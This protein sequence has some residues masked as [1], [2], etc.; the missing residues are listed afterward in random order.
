MLGWL[1]LKNPNSRWEDDSRSTWN[2]CGR[3]LKI[4]ATYLPGIH[5][6]SAGFELLPKKRTYV[7]SKRIGYSTHTQDM[8]HLDDS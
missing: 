2:R 8:R 6:D 1:L 7:G 4:E 5:T 3:K